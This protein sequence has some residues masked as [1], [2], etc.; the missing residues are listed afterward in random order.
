MY[1]VTYLQHIIRRIVLTSN[2]INYNL[3]TISV[4]LK[5]FIFDNT[6]SKSAVLID[7]FELQIACSHSR[8]HACISNSINEIWH[9]YNSTIDWHRIHLT[10]KISW[11]VPDFLEGSTKFP[12]ISWLVL[13]TL[14]SILSFLTFPDR[15]KPVIIIHTGMWK[16]TFKVTK[17][18][19]FT[20][21][22]V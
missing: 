6:S 17:L 19:K 5:W 2:T 13:T 15:M 18:K 8:L 20:C 11:L 10:D 3:I 9:W 16:L 21:N 4:N 1:K 22:P 12:D 7:I 14:K